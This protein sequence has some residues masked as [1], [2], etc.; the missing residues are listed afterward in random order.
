MC[1]MDCFNCIHED[2][3]N[4]DELYDPISTELDKEIRGNKKKN[5]NQSKYFKSEKGK[6]SLKKYFESDKGKTALKRYAQSEKGKE[7]ARRYAKSTKGR[8]SNRTACRNYYLRHRE[9]ILARKRLE[10]AV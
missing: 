2:C 3:I 9:E 7:T 4:T 10:G 5:L 8:E 1:N 6:K